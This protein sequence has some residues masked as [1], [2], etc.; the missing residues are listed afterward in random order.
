MADREPEKTCKDCR[1]RLCDPITAM[2]ERVDAFVSAR[3]LIK[4]IPRQDDDPIT[5]HEVLVVANWLYEGSGNG[6]DD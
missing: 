4:E 5:A 6:D 2:A 3:N 1:C